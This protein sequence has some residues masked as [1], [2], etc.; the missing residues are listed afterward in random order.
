V[1]NRHALLLGCL[2]PL[3]L[4]LVLASASR[5]IED[6]DAPLPTDPRVI[7]ANSLLGNETQRE[8]VIRLYR[9][10]LA[11]NPDDDTARMW[12]ARV[13][14]WDGRF[15]ESLAHYARFLERAD[16]PPWAAVERATVLSWA[17]RYGDA[18]AAFHEILARDPR[19]AQALRGLARV[20]QWSGR[21]QKAAGTYERSLAI[22]DDAEARRDLAGLRA[23]RSTQGES[24][25]D[26]FTDSDDFRMATFSVRGT[27]DIDLA[28]QVIGRTGYTYVDAKRS[29]DPDANELAA[30]DGSTQSFDALVGIQRQ[31]D[32]GFVA[33]ASVGGR[34]WESAPS[35][36]LGEAAV[37]W[38]IAD[39]LS[40]GVEF[41][42]G[43]FL[44]RS[45]SLDAVLE[46]VDDLSV[47]GWSWA[48]L[49]PILAAYAYAETSFILNDEQL[50]TRT[51]AGQDVQV[52][53]KSGSN[54][55]VAWGISF[56]ITPWK[57][58]DV[59]LSLATDYLRYR[60]ASDLFYDPETSVDGT[61]VL[62][63]AHRFADWFELS[64]EVAGGYGYS[65]Q[66]GEAGEG[67]TYR[68]AGGPTLTFG[69]LW[70]RTQASRSESQRSDQVY[71][72]WGA[73][74][75]VGMGF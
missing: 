20:Y 31:L 63:A 30:G 18:E 72:S 8:H 16:P 53:E 34:R 42:Y 33:R 52:L 36:F 55:R 75:R 60:D 45:H 41:S 46:G 61:V 59:R 24:G 4:A 7:E 6:D 68:V 40:T 43:D 67:P 38:T 48:Q 39:G 64:A 35:T 69:K 17:G 70:I 23:T 26:Y 19:N 62:A 15:D 12:L 66:D 54:Q 47:R 37:D 21:A 22:E 9:D 74:L 32:H 56:D 14:S 11:E 50:R 29:G 49:T 27:S 13:L 10:V 25:S 71:S 2:L 44:D 5:A 73:M 28:T 1:S 58:A 65:K 3:A 51:E 57:E